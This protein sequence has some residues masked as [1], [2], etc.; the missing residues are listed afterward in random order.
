VR[1]KLERARIIDLV[2]RDRVFAGFPEALAWART[3]PPDK[4]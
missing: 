3:T 1:G 2:G 4:L